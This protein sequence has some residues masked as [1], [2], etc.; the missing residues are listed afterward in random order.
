MNSPLQSSVDLPSPSNQKAN[1]K[2]WRRRPDEEPGASSFFRRPTTRS[3]EHPSDSLPS[4]TNDGLP[5]PHAQPLDTLDP[6]EIQ[7][8][9]SMPDSMSRFFSKMPWRRTPRNG[10]S[11]DSFGRDGLAVDP[12]FGNDSTEGMYFGDAMS[13]DH[14]TSIPSTRASSRITSSGNVF[15]R[16]LSYLSNKSHRDDVSLES[17]ADFDES[18]WTPKDSAYGAACPVCGWLPKPARKTIEYTMVGLM[19]FLLVYCVVTTSI[20]ISNEHGHDSGNDSSGSNKLADDDF[21]IENTRNDDAYVYAADDAQQL[22]DL[23][24]DAY[25]VDA[26][27]AAAVN[28]D[29]TNDDAVVDDDAADDYGRYLRLF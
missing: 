11:F 9:P 10:G 25:N 20:R 18:E 13:P 3:A 27:D 23:N 21:Y 26:D 22:D 12:S 6:L 7:G 24:D 1:K 2:V 8:N 19:V 5:T 4:G 15:T 16:T 17:L 28:D 29:A 14:A